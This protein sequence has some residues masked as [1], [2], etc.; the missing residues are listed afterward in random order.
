M[1]S[2][3]HWPTCQET[4]NTGPTLNLFFS[5]ITHARNGVTILTRLKTKAR[6]LSLNA[7]IVKASIDKWIKMLNFVLGNK[8]E[9]WVNLHDTSMG[10]RK[11]LSPRQKSNP[12]PLCAFLPIDTQF[13]IQI[14][15]FDAVLSSSFF[16]AQQLK[17]FGTT[18]TTDHPGSVTGYPPAISACHIFARAH[19]CKYPCPHQSAGF[20]RTAPSPR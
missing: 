7:Y 17:T 12:W 11:N 19:P 1:T 4:P 20:Q 18:D 6:N 15:P 13:Q 5:S 14:A 9:R 8:C 2:A 16:F 3:K 10:Q